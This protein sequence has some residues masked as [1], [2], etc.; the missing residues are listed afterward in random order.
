[1]GLL[2]S[3]AG[4]AL[5]RARVQAEVELERRRLDA[6]IEHL[7]IVV[8]VLNA[9][10]D[11]TSLNAAGR[12]FAE[13]FG[14]PP[15]SWSDSFKSVRSFLPD[16]SPIP[17][18]DYQFVRAFR[19]EH[20]GA[21]EIQIVS[22]AN[23]KRKIVMGVAAP[24]QYDEA[25]R[26]TH[27]VTGFQDVSALRELADAKDRFLRIASHELRSPITSL[28][29][30]TSLLEMDP[31]AV[32]DPERR[33]VMLQRI[34]RQVD[35]LIRL[36]EQL[37][38]SARMNAT[39]VP[40]QRVPCDLIELAR[41]AT[42]LAAVS[43]GARAERVRIEAPGSLEGEFDAGRLEQVLSN[44]LGN[45]LRYSPDEAE[46]SLTL[47]ALGE[48]IRIEVRDRGIGIPEDQLEH[49]FSPFFRASNAAQ[50][51]KG[52]LGLG[53]YI[54][55]EIVKRHGG[56]MRVASKVGEGTTFTVELPR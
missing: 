35:R 50:Q 27:V 40:F 6:T 53:L 46:V 22:T 42:A 39:E 34:K 7:P 47:A 17:P 10:G 18:D 4:E 5:E 37:L 51:H 38:D 13:E 20:P 43:V 26:V 24:I 54:A 12:R 23:G 36:V 16:G 30:T 49:I 28:R 33:A 45:A 11:V 19:G 9:K 31:T 8:A 32:S 48:R 1:M 2:A 56:N 52:G 55:N 3:M 29:A 25:G 14:A 41:E 44:L 15:G 21:R